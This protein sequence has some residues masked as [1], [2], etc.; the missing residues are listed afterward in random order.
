MIFF[1]NNS[2]IKNMSLEIQAYHDSQTSEHKDIC[3]QLCTLINLELTEAESKVW[4]AHPVW[5][6]DGNPIVGYSKQKAGN[7]IDV[8]EWNVD[9]DESGSVSEGWKI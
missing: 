8:L 4:H 2:F 5:F 3:N 9:F 6:L 1:L 7:Q